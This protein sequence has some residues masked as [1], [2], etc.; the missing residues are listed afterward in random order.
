MASSKGRNKAKTIPVEEYRGK[1]L[2]WY[3]GNKRTLPWRFTGKSRPDPY[4]VWLSEVMLQQT[5]VNAVIPYFTKFLEKWPD[6][7]SLAAARSE[8]VMAAWAGLGYYARARN[9]HACAKEIAKRGGRFPKT[10]NELREL[11]GIGDYTSAAIASIAFNRPATVVDGN[12]ERV[13]A[14]YYGIDDPLP[15]VKKKLKALAHDISHEQTGRPGDFAQ[16]MM[17]LGATVCTPKSPKCGL[18]PVNAG[19]VSYYKG[20]AEKL[21]RRGEEKTRPTKVGY[22]YWVQDRKNRIL[23]HRRPEK[24][25]LGGMAGLPTSD[26]I[27][28]KRR[29]ELQDWH[30]LKNIENGRA[31]DSIHH[32]FTHFDLQ[33]IPK[34]AALAVN[35]KL[36]SGF[37]WCEESD[38]ASIGFP[39]LFKKA[40]RVFR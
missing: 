19:C 8:E 30:V 17:D 18:C 2:A 22:V 25:M 34:K 5:T 40:L 6:V 29:R 20:N 12:V 36:P 27:D 21:P 3:D 1:V 39:T 26:W 37:F 13:M 10:Q 23:V 16:A 11:P 35:R 4:M 32:S 7:E 15:G 31:Q 38:L 14:R 28:R 33:L 9:L 24:G